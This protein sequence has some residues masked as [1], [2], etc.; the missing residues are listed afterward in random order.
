MSTP[1]ATDS[2]RDASPRHPQN[3]PDIAPA[4]SRLW[5]W[6]VFAF[7]L[8]IAVWTAWFILAAHH[9]VEE[10]PLTPAPSR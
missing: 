4:Q 10:V 9:P 6:F 3:A 1:T 5:L 8:Q 2:G 7:A